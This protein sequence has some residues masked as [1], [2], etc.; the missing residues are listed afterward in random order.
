[1]PTN[2][3]AATV[4]ILHAFPIQVIKGTVKFLDAQPLPRTVEGDALPALQPL[5][6]QRFIPPDLC[7]QIF[8]GLVEIHEFIAM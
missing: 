5:L 7:S 8:Y 4:A 3:K 2:A 1:M 6:L